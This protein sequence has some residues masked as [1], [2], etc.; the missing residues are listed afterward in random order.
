VFKGGEDIVYTMYLRAVL[1]CL[2]ESVKT[3]LFLLCEGFRSSPIATS[4]CA[5]H[6]HSICI[7]SS[8]NFLLTFG[9]CSL[10]ERVF[11][12]LFRQS[13][14]STGCGVSG[15]FSPLVVAWNSVFRSVSAAGDSRPFCFV[16]LLGYICVTRLKTS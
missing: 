9:L 1:K 2:R 12:L 13:E 14:F 10:V 6:S 11:C 5:T 8:F 4:N 7:H 3:I 15:Q 16:Q